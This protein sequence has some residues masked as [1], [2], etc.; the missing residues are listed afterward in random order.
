[1][2][3]G[4]VQ[5]PARDLSL[6]RSRVRT[7][8]NSTVLQLMQQKL[9][10]ASRPRGFFVT[11]HCFLSGHRDGDLVGELFAFFLT[12]TGDDLTTSFRQRTTTIVALRFLGL[13]HFPNSR[14]TIKRVLTG[15]QPDI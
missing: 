12:V 13:D 7:E 8:P 4:L 2:L 14:P 9:A 15:A 11:D 10:P 3:G 5:L 6:E 1:M